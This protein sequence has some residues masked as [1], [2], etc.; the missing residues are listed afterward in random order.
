MVAL[1]GRLFGR[2][3]ARAAAAVVAPAA[4]D[5][6]PPEPPRFSVWEQLADDPGAQ[7]LRTQWEARWGE[8]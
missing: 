8:F 4:P 2:T 5:P 7:I 3:R 6:A 1:L